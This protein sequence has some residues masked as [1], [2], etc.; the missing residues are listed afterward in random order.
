MDYPDPDEEYELMHAE[1]FEAMNEL[2]DID[3]PCTSIP[4]KKSKRSLDFSEKCDMTIATPG[5]SSSHN[6]DYMNSPLLKEN[7]NL[8]NSPDGCLPLEESYH[9]RTASDLFGDIDDIELEERNTKRTKFLSKEERQDLLI[10]SILNKRKEILEQR[11][12]FC[13]N[14]STVSVQKDCL[15][16]ISRHVPKWPFVAVSGAD[17]HNLYLRCYSKEEYDEQIKSINLKTKTTG[18]LQVPFQELFKEAMEEILKKSEKN[19]KEI[20][21]ENIQELPKEENELWVEKYRPKSYLQLLSDESTNRALLHWLKLW[22]KVVF[23]REP[24]ILKKSKPNEKVLE[25]DESGRPQQKIALLCGPPGLGKTTLAHM[26]AKQAGYNVVEVNASDDRSTHIFRTQLEAATQMKSVMGMDPRPNCLVLDEI[27]GAPQASIEVLIK[28]VN[29]KGEKKKGKKKGGLLRRPIICICN[30]VYVP[31]LRP[32]RQIAFTLHFPPT[33]AARLGERLIEVCRLEQIKSDLGT[34]MALSEK[35]HNDIRSC[36]SLLAMMKTKGGRVTLSQVAGAKL[37]T[38]DRQQGLFAVWQTIFHIPTKKKPYSLHSKSSDM[39]EKQGNAAL[40]E[41]YRTVLRVVQSYGD[42]DRLA[43]GVYENFLN[44]RTHDSSLYPVCTGLDW[45]RFHDL[46]STSIQSSQIYSLY[47]YLPYSFVTWHRLYSSITWPKLS[48]PSIS[49]EMNQKK[50]KLLQ[51]ID[52]AFNGM[53]PY[54]QA[55]QNRERL[56]LDSIPFLLELIIP[57]I[58]PVSVQLYTPKERSEVERVIS[59][60]VDYNLNYTQE[61]TVDGNYVFNL[62]PNLE[63]VGNFKERERSRNLGYPGRQMIAKEV[64]TEK[65]RKLTQLLSE[66]QRPETKREPKDDIAK[67]IRSTPER[68]PNPKSPLPNHLQRLTPV[69]FR[70]K[71]MDTYARDFFG[72]I[73]EKSLTKEQEKA[74]TDD[75]VKSDVWFH[76]KEGYNNAVRKNV[77]IADLL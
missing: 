45:F 16:N 6:R 47:P 36:L 14:L 35:T 31:A 43:I 60:M 24:L 13:S 50:V 54:I 37:G 40:R 28:F 2:D 12:H 44:V 3:P 53:P 8:Y 18:L 15:D 27:D 11:K 70:K 26:I 56:L 7:K 75:I 59:V 9:K 32:L 62:D 42:Y 57:N 52:F 20:N 64:E 66:N 41:R 72:R 33:S 74:K 34:M 71:K 4:P 77:Y 25:L 10:N 5:P 69:A 30:D 38:K 65:L 51:I 67:C 23:N 46:M 22:D 39:E 73:V 68:S 55:Y 29:D 21:K 63:E 49:Y 76:F 61:R 19:E 58:R 48:Y 1:E 17:G